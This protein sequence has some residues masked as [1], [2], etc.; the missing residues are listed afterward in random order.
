MFQTQGEKTTPKRY[1]KL[2]FQTLKY[3]M[4]TSTTLL[5]KNPPP[6][7]ET[8]PLFGTFSKIVRRRLRF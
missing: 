6:G 3:T 1:Q 7:T 4:S 5:Y 2:E 8:R